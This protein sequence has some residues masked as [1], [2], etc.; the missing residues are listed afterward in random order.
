MLKRAHKYVTISIF[1]EQV[2]MWGNI[3]GKISVSEA[4]QNFLNNTT[5]L[6]NTLETVYGVTGY[7]VNT[8]LG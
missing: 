2:K 3:A 5:H 4:V 7:R 6:L 1:I 8:D